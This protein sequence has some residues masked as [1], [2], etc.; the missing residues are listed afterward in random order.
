M[1][2]LSQIALVF[3]GYMKDL[4]VRV[5]HKISLNRFR[6]AWTLRLHLKPFAKIVSN[7]ICG[8]QTLINFDSN[9]FS[10]RLNY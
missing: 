7:S 2:F 3:L 1:V 4:Y 6:N 10:D 5:L 9:Y 8:T